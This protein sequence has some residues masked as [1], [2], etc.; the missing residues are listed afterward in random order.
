MVFVLMK[1]SI[2]RVYA[3][4]LKVKGMQELVQA[5]ADEKIRDE[6]RMVRIAKFSV[7]L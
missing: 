3:S 6:K 1:A 2:L 4:R 7:D 5:Y